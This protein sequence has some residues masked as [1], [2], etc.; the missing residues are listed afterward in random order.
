M[1]N[2]QQ[3]APTPLDTSEVQL[4]GELMALAEMLARNTHEVWSQG[5]MSQGWTWGEVRDDNR[6]THPGLIPYEQLTEEEKDYDRHTTQET[7]K[8]ILSLGFEIVRKGR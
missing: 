4:P 3:Y 8:L 7:L 1:M 5:R 6:K 2:K